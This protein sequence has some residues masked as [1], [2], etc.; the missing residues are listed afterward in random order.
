MEEHEAIMAALEA[1]DAARV[2]DELRNHLGKTWIK[3]TNGEEDIGQPENL[4][5]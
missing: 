2:G 4:T 1:R 3:Y 5:L